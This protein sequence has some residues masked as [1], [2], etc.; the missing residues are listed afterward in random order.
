MQTNERTWHEIQK[1][2]SHRVNSK[3]RTKSGI[4]IAVGFETFRVESK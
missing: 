1:S 2:Q 3:F 4:E